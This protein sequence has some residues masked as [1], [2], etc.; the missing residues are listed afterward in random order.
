MNPRQAV[1]V[2]TS[3]FFAGLDRADRHHGAAVR[4]F[5]E[6]A[7]E[8]RAI[9]TSNVIVAETHALALR[10]LGRRAALRWLDQPEIYLIFE[11]PDDHPSVVTLLERYSDK[12]FSYADAV[13]FVLMERLGIGVAFAFDDDFRQYGLDVIP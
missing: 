3:A 8:G 5:E 11:E 4:T 13:S 2:D 12:N 10:R 7:R 1:F 9:Y 6:L